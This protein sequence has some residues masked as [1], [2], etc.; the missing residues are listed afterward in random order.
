MSWI[1]ISGPDRAWVRPETFDAPDVPRDRLM[2]RGSIVVETRLSPDGRPQ[3]LLGYHR[4]H[5]WNAGISLQAVPGGGIVLILNQGEDVFHTVLD[6]GRDA[7]TDTLRVTFSWDAPRRWGRLAVE[8]PESD[9]LNWIVTPAPL[10]II[11]ED[12]FTM[13][14]RPQLRQMD[15]DVVFFAVS[16]RI[17]PIGPMPALTGDVPIATPRGYRPLRDLQ[18]GDTVMTRDNGVVPVLHKVDRVVPALGAFRPV[19]LRAPYFGLVRDIVVAPHQR[20]VIGGTDVEYIFGQEAVLIPA[21]NLVN[22]M[23]AVFEDG[24]DF[25]RYAQVLLPGHAAL[26]AANAAVESLYI[27]RLRRRKDDLAASLLHDC[28]SQLLPD[29]YRAGYQVLQPFEAITLAETRAA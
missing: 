8:R 11:V 23:A 26:I 19:R 28:P 13:V 21:L 16:D 24:H 10:P 9:A 14:R 3:T 20:L 15:R 4:Q 7:R 25:V 27:G 22:G 1:A 5:P 17:E 12:I 6:H 29:H 18:L 2:T